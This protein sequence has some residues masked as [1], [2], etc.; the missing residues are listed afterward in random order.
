MKN[1]TIRQKTTSL[2]TQQETVCL[3][4]EERQVTW[5]TPCTAEGKTVT[6]SQN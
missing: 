3:L 2:Q 4:S 6:Q 5:G 1:I